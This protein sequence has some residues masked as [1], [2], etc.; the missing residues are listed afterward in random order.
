M[1]TKPS[2]VV[3]AGA[4]LASLAIAPPAN[5]AG[6]VAGVLDL[7]NVAGMGGSVTPISSPTLNLSEGEL[8]QRLEKI[9]KE[10]S[11]FTPAAED[12]ASATT[13]LVLSQVTSGRIALSGIARSNLTWS[14][15]TVLENKDG[16]R[17]VR[18]PAAR[19]A[20]DPSAVTVA[21]EPT[22]KATVV[23][24][25]F[26]PV[27]ATAMRLELFVDGALQMDKIAD[28]ANRTVVDSSQWKPAGMGAQ[29]DWG[30]FESCLAARGIPWTTVALLS[31]ACGVA[32]AITLGAGCAVCISAAGAIS[33]ATVEYCIRV[34]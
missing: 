31:V 13:D 26:T 8:K 23:E 32:C 7:S 15:T 12:R 27:S 22:G 11:A 9:T 6:P 16:V 17:I 21:I 25:K 34:N 19:A 24:N 14:G 20:D 29:F 33:I 18:V 2:V 28:S 4:L 30:R 10:A 1:I 3:A 5:A